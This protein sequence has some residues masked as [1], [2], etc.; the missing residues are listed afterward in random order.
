M[1]VEEQTTGWQHYAEAEGPPR[2]GSWCIDELGKLFN[3]YT[4]ELNEEAKRILQNAIQE[5]AG[6][7]DCKEIYTVTVQIWIW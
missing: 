4:A 6:K 1:S 2:V 3:Q 7:P 5:E